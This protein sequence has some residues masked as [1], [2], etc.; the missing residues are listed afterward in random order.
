V[1]I[2]GVTVTVKVA[3]VRLCHSRR[4]F[5][6]AHPRETLEMMFD[7]HNRAFAFV[8]GTCTHGIYDNMKTAVEAGSSAKTASSAA[9]FCGCAGI[10]W[11]SPLPARRPRA[12]KRGRACPR[13]SGGR[14]PG[15]GRARAFLYAA[16]AG[17]ERSLS[18]GR[19]KRGPGGGAEPDPVSVA[20]AVIDAVRAAL[21]VRA[22]GQTF[23]FELHQALRG[24]THH[25]AQQIGIRA[26]L[27]QRAKAHHLVGHRRVL[28]LG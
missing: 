21:A 5:V 2:N 22:T 6:R 23:D 14:E 25:L 4:L 17:G 1:L 8:K 26:L 9:A 3:H 12:G 15:W 16:A 7:T 20:I 19:A 11:S 27:Q 28:G 18:S 10:T 24:K 13:E